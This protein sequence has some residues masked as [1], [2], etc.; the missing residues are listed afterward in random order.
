MAHA[1]P[2]AL[3]IVLNA[4]HHAT[5]SLETSL[6]TLP[7]VLND[8]AFGGAEMNPKIAFVAYCVAA[9]FIL[10]VAFHSVSMTLVT[11]DVPA[12]TDVK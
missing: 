7:R 4:A 12:V 3:L 10:A 11:A 5:K 8:P 6:A 9:G 1:R 2:H